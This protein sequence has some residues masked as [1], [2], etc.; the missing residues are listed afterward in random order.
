MFKICSV[1]NCGAVTYA[2]SLCRQHYNRLR[3]HGRLDKIKGLEKPICSFDGCLNRASGS[4][5]HGLCNSHNE[6]KFHSGVLKKLETGGLREH[7]LYNIWYQRKTYN[8]LCDRW[9]DFRN[10]LNDVE[11]RPSKDH[12]LIRLREGLFG[13]DNFKWEEHLRK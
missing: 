1:E 13:P 3:I 4:N 9:L 2:K 5:P 11:P 12:Y 6:M 10:F 7:A 8:T